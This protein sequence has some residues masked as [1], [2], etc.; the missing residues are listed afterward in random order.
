MMINTA[1]HDWY[2]DDCLPP[3]HTDLG[4][5]ASEC[6]G[7]IVERLGAAGRPVAEADERNRQHAEHEEE[8]RSG[9]HEVKVLV[10][11]DAERRQL[12]SGHVVAAHGV[13]DVTLVGVAL[14]RTGQVAVPLGLR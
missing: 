5:H 13:G 11:A 6:R 2:D 14:P 10:H 7:W 4:R 12:V 1:R 9:A 3:R 8:D